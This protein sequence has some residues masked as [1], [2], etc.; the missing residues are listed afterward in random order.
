MKLNSGF[1]APWN[2]LL[3]PVPFMLVDCRLLP[4]IHVTM[5]LGPFEIYR[6]DSNSLFIHSIGSS[7][8]SPKSCYFPEAHVLMFTLNPFSYFFWALDLILISAPGAILISVCHAY[9]KTKPKPPFKEG[10]EWCV[11]GLSWRFSG[12]KEFYLT[13]P[14]SDLVNNWMFQ[15]PAT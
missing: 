8:S 5:V 15:T 3:C 13:G 7:V 1:Q 4:F 6:V 2:W 9:S 12:M 10:I 11:K 14:N